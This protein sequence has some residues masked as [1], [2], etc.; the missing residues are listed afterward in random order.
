MKLLST[1]IALR[2]TSSSVTASFMDIQWYSRN[3]FCR[4]RP[5]TKLWFVMYNGYSVADAT[6]AGIPVVQCCP[7]SQP[8]CSGDHLRWR[9]WW[10]FVLSK[11][12]LGKSSASQTRSTWPWR[13]SRE[14]R[15]VQTPLSPSS[16]CDYWKPSLCESM[17]KAVR[18][19][20]TGSF[21]PFLYAALKEMCTKKLWSMV[22]RSP[23]RS[24]KW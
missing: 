16:P 19:N 24:F 11:S 22:S 7:A 15:H 10:L 2:Q 18:S 9:Q 1:G 20:I 8:Q 4:I 21:P 17:W 6:L 12:Y 5:S 3:Y 13:P 23:S 14:H